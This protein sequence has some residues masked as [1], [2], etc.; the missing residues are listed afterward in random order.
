M[1]EIIKS[2][3]VK[4]YEKDTSRI[5]QMLLKDPTKIPSIILTQQKELKILIEYSELLKKE[6]SAEINIVKAE[7]SQ[8]KKAANAMP[9]KPAIVVS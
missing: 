3:L 1:S 5:V 6:F 8:E 9:G 4:G 7:D 2:A